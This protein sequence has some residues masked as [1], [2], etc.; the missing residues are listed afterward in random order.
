MEQNSIGAEGDKSIVK[1]RIC[2]IFPELVYIWFLQMC[3]DYLS[4]S[5]WHLEPLTERSHSENE[6]LV[7]LEVT[8]ATK[9]FLVII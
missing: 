8:S 4:V 9:L 5:S 3:Y 7:G 2:T 6:A 1:C